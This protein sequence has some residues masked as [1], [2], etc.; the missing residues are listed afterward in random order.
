MTTRTPEEQRLDALLGV[1]REDLPSIDEQDAR[2]Q[3][4]DAA[5]K[6]GTVVA[7][8]VAAST[9]VRA[10]ALW[11]KVVLGVSAAATVT[12][13]VAKQVVEQAQQ[14]R[15][16]EVRTKRG[17]PGS[18]QPGLVFE[19][20]RATIEPTAEA[21]EL[22]GST[23]EVPATSPVDGAAS[24]PAAALPLGIVAPPETAGTTDAPKTAAMPE[25]G[26]A[27]GATSSPTPSA[28]LSVAASG[29]SG[30]SVP[31]AAEATVAVA[32]RGTS[33]SV[34]ALPTNAVV[35]PG[36]TGTPSPTLPQ[37]A[38]AAVATTGSRGATLQTLPLRANAA[39]AATAGTATP[40]PTLPPPAN[41]ALATTGRS[42]TTD[43][44]TSQTLP[45]RVDAATGSS[46]LTA[47]PST[48]ARD[49]SLKSP[50]AAPLPSR[51][52]GA[53]PAARAP[54]QLLP[55]EGPAVSQAHPT[56]D[57]AA[58]AVLINDAHLLLTVDPQR[59]LTRCAEHQRRWPTGALALEREVLII[60]ALT[61]LGR[62]AEAQ[63]HAATFAAQNPTSIHL[64]RVRALTNE[65]P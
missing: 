41:V 10:T 44:A 12:V 33:S 8:G 30:T 23:L 60:E 3:M 17:A 62:K 42:G 20:E 18:P 46:G 57:L 19:V 31:P 27:D 26:N 36:G 58:E 35:A 4:V 37:P 13:M 40:S 1:A 59:T 6:A 50:G 48:G 54:P 2:W 5:V 49:D 61:A 32:A 34:P 22:R 63:A 43:G 21:E 25:S 56:E 47:P 29:T 11:L 55:A 24:T 15:A 52:T 7:V 28:R 16:P 38:N 53:S 51:G 45:P 9:G 39:V 14:P 65:R 64:P